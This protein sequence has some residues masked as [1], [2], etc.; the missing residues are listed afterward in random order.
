VAAVAAAAVAFT[1]IFPRLNKPGSSGSMSPPRLPA[2]AADINGDGRVDILDAYVVA[3]TLAD[4]S[5][6]TS[7]PAAWD[8]NHDGVVDQKDVDWIAKAAVQ[9][10]NRA[11][12]AGDSRPADSAAVFELAQ[13][14]KSLNANAPPSEAPITTALGPA[15]IDPHSDPAKGA[16]AP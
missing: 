8:L 13:D 7:L 15:A 2:L 4:R 3:R 11:T 14:L 6:K 5:R 1:V 9:V 10:G 12:A 16:A